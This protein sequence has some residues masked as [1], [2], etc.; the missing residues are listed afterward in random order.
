M[1][2]LQPKCTKFATTP[3]E[4]LYEEVVDKKYSL[5]Y[6]ITN[7]LQFENDVISRTFEKEPTNN[8]DFTN[9]KVSN[10]HFYSVTLKFQILLSKVSS[11][12]NKLLKFEVA[13]I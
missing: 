12:Q 6:W 9:W 2:I 11:F 4:K 1:S 13:S 7:W 10:F 3:R 8:F 5:L